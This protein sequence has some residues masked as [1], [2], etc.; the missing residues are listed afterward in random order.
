[1]NGG[2]QSKKKKGEKNVQASIT[3]LPLKVSFIVFY[4]ESVL[5]QIFLSMFACCSSR[6]EEEKQV[7][8]NVDRIQ[9][10]QFKKQVRLL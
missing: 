4:W 10:F 9:E 2:L 8:N 1:M 5:C 6:L 7:L 3:L